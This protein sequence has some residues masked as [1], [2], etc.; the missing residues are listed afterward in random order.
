MIAFLLPY[1]PSVNRMYRIARNRFYKHK[2]YVQWTMAADVMLRKQIP[3]LRKFTEPVRVSVLVG[4]PDKRKRD[5]DNILKATADFMETV[6]LVENDHLIH[7]WYVRW[8]EG[9]KNAVY[10]EIRPM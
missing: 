5:L 4:R 3:V 8:D 10:V 9:T 6:E 7:E 1:P 2:D